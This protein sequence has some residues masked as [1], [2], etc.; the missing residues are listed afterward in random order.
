MNKGLEKKKKIVYD[1]ICDDLYIPMKAKELA[2][3]LQVS[4]EQR[5][6]LREVLDALVT[7]GKV[8]ISKKGKYVKGEARHLVG[9]YQANSRGFGF[10]ILEDEEANDIFISDDDANGAFQGTK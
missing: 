8:T 5:Q 10:V 7:E 3:I 1:F 2:V 4:K 6:E 9:T